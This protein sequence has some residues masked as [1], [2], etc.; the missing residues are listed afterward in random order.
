MLAVTAGA[1]PQMPGRSSIDHEERDRQLCT[2]SFG[3]RVPQDRDFHLLRLGESDRDRQAED[4]PQ[5]NERQVRTT[6]EAD[7]ARSTSP[8]VAHAR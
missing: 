8:L 7:P 4:P 6:T 3:E 2:F 5:D 1:M